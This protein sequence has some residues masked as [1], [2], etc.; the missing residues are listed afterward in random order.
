VTKSLRALGLMSGTSMD[1][2]DVAL[3]TTDG[4]HLVERGPGATFAYPEA[5][6][7]QLRQAAAE[8]Q[9][10]L[11]R[12]ARPGNLAG[13]EAELTQ[14]H[15][16]AVG[17]FLAVQAIDPASIDVIG[18]HGQTVLHRPEQKLTVQLGD[19]PLLACLT[20]IDVVYDLRA[21]DVAAGGQ[22]APLVP[23]Y[24]RALASRFEE[25]VAFLNIGGIANVTFVG[26]KPPLIAFD[27]GPGNALIDDWV[28]RHTGKLQDTDGAIAARGTVHNEVLDVIAFGGYYSAPPPK[29]LDRA[30]LSLKAVEGLSLADGA[31]TL[32]CLTALTIS[33]AP[34]FFPER[35]SVWIVGGGGR[36]NRT[37][38]V[39]T[40]GILG[41]QVV[42]AEDF[43]FDGDAME[44][45]AWAYLA[46]RSLR[47]LP[48]TYPMTTG[49]PSPMTGGRLATGKR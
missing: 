40:A 43:G 32:T 36:L 8:A 27:T 4:E 16:D 48:I 46:V 17:A 2:I 12:T 3:I 5:F 9:D 31:A 30:A 28:R 21:A 11:Q 44:A 6:R 10:L 41:A 47:G 45:E 1:G 24:H 23:V 42:P 38:M 7:V 15:A 33:Q 35:P 20:G 29:S 18:F 19:G 13:A 22:G 14:R 25:A 37:M 39:M 26:T 49:V 34:Q